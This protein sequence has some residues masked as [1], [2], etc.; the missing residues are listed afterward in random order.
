MQS[1]KVKV[2]IFLATNLCT[3]LFIYT[4]P[5]QNARTH[6]QRPLAQAKQ[7]HNM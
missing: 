5:P 7:I 3:L 4:L 1:Y 2:V 6:K